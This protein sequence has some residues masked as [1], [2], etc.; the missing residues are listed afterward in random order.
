MAKIRVFSA[1]TQCP[2]KGQEAGPAQIRSTSE[3]QHSRHS[4][5][6]NRWNPDLWP[7]VP[8][9]ISA[10]FWWPKEQIFA[11]EFYFI[12]YFYD[13][14]FPL[15]PKKTRSSYFISSSNWLL[16]W[17]ISEPLEYCVTFQTLQTHAC[18]DKT[19][20]SQPA[21]IKEITCELTQDN[22]K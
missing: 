10:T 5:Q 2:K 19:G 20:V 1:N 12:K 18:S 15:K 11:S 3:Q 22:R 17:T 7:L 14:Y 21:S 9:G 4:P 13:I 8:Q 6:M 16:K